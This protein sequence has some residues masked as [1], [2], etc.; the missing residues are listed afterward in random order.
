MK[1]SNNV[2]INKGKIL[3]Y[4]FKMKVNVHFISIVLISLPRL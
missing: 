2:Y 3:I 4:D 1:N